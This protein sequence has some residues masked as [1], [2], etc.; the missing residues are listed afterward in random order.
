MSPNFEDLGVALGKN[1]EN[2]YWS[3]VTF[4]L[5]HPSPPDI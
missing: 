4:L 3:I 2:I 1:E 5:S